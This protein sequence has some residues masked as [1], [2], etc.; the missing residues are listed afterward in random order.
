[1]PP[2]AARGS[3][4]VVSIDVPVPPLL[5]NSGARFIR[6]TG[7]QSDHRVGQMDVLFSPDWKSGEYTEKRAA[8]SLAN[9]ACSITEYW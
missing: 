5:K 3:N 6:D 2:D 7:H 9:V 4:S 8:A 1:L